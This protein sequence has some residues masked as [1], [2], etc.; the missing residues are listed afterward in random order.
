MRLYVNNMPNVECEYAKE[1]R[2]L[3]LTKGGSSQGTM[4]GTLL[5]ERLDVVVRKR[6]KVYL[7]AKKTPPIDVQVHLV[8]DA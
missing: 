2:R 5:F 6:L 4:T 7:C 3:T 1:E 8:G